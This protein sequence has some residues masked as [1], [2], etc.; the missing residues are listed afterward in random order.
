MIRRRR[1]GRNGFPLP[2]K[3]PGVEKEISLVAAGVP[4]FGRSRAGQESYY[5]LP[6]LR[7]ALEI[8]RCPDSLVSVPHVFLTHAH[9]DH[10][11]G[12]ATY[13]SQRTLHAMEPGRLFMPEE[14]L[15]DFAE[16]LDR[17]RR[18]EGVDRY[19]ADLVGLSPGARVRLRGDLF[20]RTFPGRHRVPTIGYTF[21]ES[22][23]KLKAE[24]RETP[25]DRLAALRAAGTEIA[26]LVET[27]LLSYPGDSTEEIFEA[28]P[29]ILRSRVLI[30][31]CT[32]LRPGDEE[33][34]H[35]FSHLHLRDIAARASLFE[36]EVL[37]L[38][39]FSARHS[40]EEI[41]AL[42]QGGLPPALLERTVAFV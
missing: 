29:E 27:P 2:A 6:T 26:E 18:L 5:R 36:N 9:L 28:A 14:V 4:I 1:G 21:C 13:A 10:A 39:H 17:H 33:R 22:K 12:V 11:A 20:V 42:L 38:T 25:G 40:G 15:E 7:A 16:I 3:L 19:Q 32:F 30:L 41:R 31:E 34:A 8:G 37:V 23:R 24:F 35:R